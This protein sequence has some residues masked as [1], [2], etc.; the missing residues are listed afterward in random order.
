[1]RYRSSSHSRTTLQLCV[2][3]RFRTKRDAKGRIVSVRDSR[4]NGVETDYDDASAP[5]AGSAKRLQAYP[6]AVLRLLWAE[7]T[8][9]GGKPAPE[10]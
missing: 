10:L 9:A 5:A 4:G 8:P 2:P 6:F 7:T 1:M 3:G